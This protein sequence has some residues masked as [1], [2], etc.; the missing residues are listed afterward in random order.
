MQIAAQNIHSCIKMCMKTLNQEVGQKHD[1]KG[2]IKWS[3]KRPASRSS[4]WVC[5][6]LGLLKQNLIKAIL[7]L[8]CV[9]CNPHSICLPTYQPQVN[10]G[11]ALNFEVNLTQN[12]IRWGSHLQQ[13][14]AT[15]KLQSFIAEVLVVLMMRMSSE[16]LKSAE[17]LK[18]VLKSVFRVAD[19]GDYCKI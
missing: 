11:P 4:T 17:T 16:K 3:F 7:L 5:S 6:N 9:K 12:F 8:P 10:N 2:C 18:M 1:K 14:T 13:H 19:C 15:S